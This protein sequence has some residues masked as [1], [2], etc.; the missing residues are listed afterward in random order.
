MDL[1]V[2]EPS[3]GIYLLD[4]CSISPNLAR[5][6]A[7]CALCHWWSWLWMFRIKSGEIRRIT[8]EA[9]DAKHKRTGD[10]K[11]HKPLSDKDDRIKAFAD[12]SQGEWRIL[13][14]GGQVAGVSEGRAHD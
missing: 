14:V 9:W 10:H 7:V 4:C 2:R 11:Q 5:S 1:I 12:R 8:K 3:M 13:R 6:K